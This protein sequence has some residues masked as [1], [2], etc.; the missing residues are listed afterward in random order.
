MKTQ[1]TEV[2]QCVRRWPRSKLP[3]GIYDGIFRMGDL[4]I[5]ITGEHMV[6]R[7]IACFIP[8]FDLTVHSNADFLIH[9]HSE[10]LLSFAMIADPYKT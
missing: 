2:T 1:N 4:F 6:H 3:V 8:P 5:F 9:L 7:D 10:G